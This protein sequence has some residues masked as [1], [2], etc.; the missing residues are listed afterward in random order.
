[1]TRNLFFLGFEFHPTNLD[2]LG[3]NQIRQ[4]GKYPGG[5]IMGLGATTRDNIARYKMINDSIHHG[6]FHDLD[7]YSFLHDKVILT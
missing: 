3:I 7:V 4:Q 2:R 1:V 6:K 5:T